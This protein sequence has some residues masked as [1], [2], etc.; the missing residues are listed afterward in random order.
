ML[1]SSCHT[2]YTKINI[3]YNLARRLKTII[4]EQ[5]KQNDPESLIEGGVMM[6]VQ[7]KFLVI[8][9]KSSRK[10]NFRFSYIVLSSIL[11]YK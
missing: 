6:Q 3:P 7:F 9:D 5:L 11:Y 2:M 1:F 4:S 8:T 10:E